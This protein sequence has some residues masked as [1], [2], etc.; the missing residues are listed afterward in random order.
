MKLSAEVL[1]YIQNVKNFV[2]KN[3]EAKRYFLIYY[4]ENVFYEKLSEIAQ[5]N[6]NDKGNPMLTSEQFELLRTPS[7]KKYNDD[8]ITKINENIFIEFNGYEKI[9]LN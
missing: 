4:S 5:S 8:Y 3:E 9:C 6:F 1:M 2:N 7:D